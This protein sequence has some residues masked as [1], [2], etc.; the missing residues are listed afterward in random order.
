MIVAAHERPFLVI[1]GLGPAIQQFEGTLFRWMR[2]SSPR[3]T[4]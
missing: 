2:G 1:A 4:M 3:M